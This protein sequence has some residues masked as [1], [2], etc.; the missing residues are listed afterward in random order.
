MKIR[1]DED[2]ND[3]VDVDAGALLHRLKKICGKRNAE[4]MMVIITT[5]NSE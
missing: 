4:M 2:D 1:I 3:D 5:R